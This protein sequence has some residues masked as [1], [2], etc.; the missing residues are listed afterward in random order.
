MEVPTTKLRKARAIISLQ[1]T[2]KSGKKAVIRFFL[3]G[4]VSLVKHNVKLKLTTRSFFLVSLV[5]P[6][7]RIKHN[8]KLKL[9][10]SSF[11]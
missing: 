3:V 11:C 2:H 1:E 8:V 10:A 7:S 5:G 6:V 9:T 4:L